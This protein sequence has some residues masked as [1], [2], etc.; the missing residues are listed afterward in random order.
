MKCQW[1]DCTAEIEPDDFKE[2]TTEH[3]KQGTELICQWK[4]CTR[5]GE[6]FGNKYTLQAHMRIHSGD[7]PFRCSLCG[8]NFSRM[9]ALNKHQKRH[10]EEERRMK[11][12]LGKLLSTYTAR[13]AEEETIRFLL[14]ERQFE[15]DCLRLL[16]D[17]LLKKVPKK[18][19]KGPDMFN[20]HYMNGN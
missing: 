3:I 8:S 13:K 4:G 12:M 20:F 15:V 2:H 7:K 1:G 9:D 11:G 19:E 6:I 10:E 16:S 5:N 17:E 18:E 14:G